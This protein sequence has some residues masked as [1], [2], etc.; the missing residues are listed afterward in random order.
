M[1]ESLLHASDIQGTWHLWLLIFIRAG[2][3]LIINNF[4]N[5]QNSLPTQGQNTIGNHLWIKNC[6]WDHCQGAFLTLI[7]DNKSTILAGPLYGF[8]SLLAFHKETT[9]HTTSNIIIYIY[10]CIRVHLL[11]LYMHLYIH[12]CTFVYIIC[13]NLILSDLSSF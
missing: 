6:A 2:G 3:Q 13:M 12:V 4:M 8:V 1:M 11:I 9:K 10:K 7:R 5:L